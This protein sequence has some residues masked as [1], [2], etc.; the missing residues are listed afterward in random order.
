[1]ST[2]SKTSRP[3]ILDTLHFSVAAVKIS[4]GEHSVVVPTP[5]WERLISLTPAE[6][7]AARTII[8]GDHEAG[9]LE[10]DHE[11]EEA[12]EADLPDADRSPL[13]T[14]PL[15][16]D[17][18]SVEVPGVTVVTFRDDP[19]NVP[20]ATDGR[21]RQ[22][23]ESVTGIVVHTTGGR[24][25]QLKPKFKASSRALNLARYQA[26]TKRE[27][28]W[29]LT[30][31]TDGTV[32]QSADTSWLCWH[33]GH[34]NARTVGIELV[35]DLDGT[36]YEDQ[37]AAAVRVID[38]LCRELGVPRRVPVRDGEPFDKIL[39][40]DDMFVGVYGHRN[41]WKLQKAGPGKFKKVGT[42]GPGDPGDWIFKAL[43]AEGFAGH[44]V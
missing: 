6:Q 43:L 29:H 25:G 27:V 37:L 39:V 12:A 16:I 11:E 26:N 42:R 7:M 20:R 4:D 23:H 3:D 1:M 41:V 22:A 10:H 14:G 2:E 31:D 18:R 36:V 8:N 38:V 5:L 21:R 30:I 17:G 24:R 15:V 34:V 33:A 9:E 35:Q 40:P 19:K 28:S 13:I 44:E 32:V